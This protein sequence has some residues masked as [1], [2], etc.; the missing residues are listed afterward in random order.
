[1]SIGAPEILFLLFVLYPLF[2]HFA[3]SAKN[4]RK[5][6]NLLLIISLTP[7]FWIIVACLKNKNE[8]R[9]SKNVNFLCLA[10]AFI[11]FAII[12]AMKR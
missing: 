7:L 11:N 6:W 5:W 2:G 9:H 12:L 1:M 3:L 10:W 8:E 4:Y